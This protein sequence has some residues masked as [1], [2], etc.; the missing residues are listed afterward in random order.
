MAPVNQF[1]FGSVTS[2]LSDGF[3]LG[4]TELHVSPPKAGCHHSYCA[5]VMRPVVEGVKSWRGSWSGRIGGWRRGGVEGWRDAKVKEW[6]GGGVVEGWY[7]VGSGRLP[8][9]ASANRSRQCWG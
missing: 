7:T 8:L 2:V 1:A 9:R 5:M 6:R 3:F 4:A